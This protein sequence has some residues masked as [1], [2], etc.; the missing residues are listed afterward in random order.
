[1]RVIGGSLRGR[2]LGRVPEGV[3]PTSDRVRESLF[4]M[5]G[6]LDGWNVLD[7]YAGTGALGLEAHS[8]GAQRV[9]FC[10]RSRKVV[11]ALEARLR[12]LGLEQGEALRVLPLDARRALRRLQ[13]DAE[14]HFDCVFF[15][16][17]YAATDRVETLEMLF[18]SPILSADPTVVVEVPTRETWSPVHGAR[19]VDQR[20]YGDTMLV[21]LGR[22]GSQEE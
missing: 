8:R 19:V 4:S 11:R 18:A 3:R 22:S 7:L 10:E 13:A 20:R 14:L 1:M 12:A 2:D 16:P 9:V 21:W 5:L 17:P 6:P 15:D